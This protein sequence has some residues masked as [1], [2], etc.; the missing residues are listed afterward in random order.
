[1]KTTRQYGKQDTKQT[2]KHNERHG[3]P[4]YIIAHLLEE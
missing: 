2:H 4:L 3:L 1:M